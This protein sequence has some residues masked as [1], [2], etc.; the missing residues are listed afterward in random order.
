M[1]ITAEQLE[2]L[3]QR[4]TPKTP[5]RHFTHCT[6]RFGGTRSHEAVEDFIASADFYKDS[7]EI[8][9]ANALSG[10]SILLQGDAFTWWMGVKSTITT[11][12]NAKKAIR[13]EFA[14][15]P[16]AHRIYKMIFE[17][18]QDANTPTGLFI[19]QKRALLAQVTPPDSE[20]RQLDFLYGLLRQEIKDK[21]PRTSIATFYKLL[22]KARDVEGT[23][24]ER[25]KEKVR[26]N[27]E[28]GRNRC[29][30]CHNFGHTVKDCRKQAKRAAQ[31]TAEPNNVAQAANNTNFSCYGCGHPGV[32]RRNCPKC[33]NKPV[34]AAP[35][36]Q[37][38]LLDVKLLGRP[39]VKIQIHGVP[40]TAYI[41]S[42][43]RTSLASASA[44]LYHIL[45]ERGHK[46]L[47]T[48][49]QLVQADGSSTLTNVKIATLS[50]KLQGKE[51]E[52][53]FI[54]IP[55]A[56]E[57]TT[58]LGIDFLR[59]AGLVINY[60]HSRWHF[61]GQRHQTYGFVAKDQTQ[62]DTQMTAMQTDSIVSFQ[63]TVPQQRTPQRVDTVMQ[64]ETDTPTQVD[65]IQI[66]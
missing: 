34:S 24:Q 23:L 50:V 42:G 14:P 40:G 30:Y 38:C 22:A 36:V 39:A 66:K 54:T 65:K 52:T 60:A 1:A 8:A 19:A 29:E 49:V 45:T 27:D 10:L 63:S 47:P 25:K 51:I 53:T 31:Q 59:K 26:P 56:H 15:R 58:L 28:N 11:W 13:D 17:T 4:L 64:M 48:T 5:K 9:D 7:E 46:F 41:D 57:T 44:Q 3:I 61:S 2:Q 6:A 55:D 32:I 43:A 12:E 21:I 62:K 16:P 20:S 37:F 35:D 18:K 33:N